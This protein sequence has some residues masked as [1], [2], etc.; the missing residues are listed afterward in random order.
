MITVQRGFKSRPDHRMWRKDCKITA[1][2]PLKPAHALVT[3]AVPIQS[4]FL[5]QA[6]ISTGGLSRAHS[7]LCL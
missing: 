4:G 1:I 7:P 2:V 3:Q 6:A 5:D